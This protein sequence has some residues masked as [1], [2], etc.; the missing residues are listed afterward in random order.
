MDWTNEMYGFLTL[1]LLLLG[2][3]AGWSLF[4]GGGIWYALARSFSLLLRAMWQF[5]SF[6]RLVFSWVFQSGKDNQGGAR[7]AT[8]IE[9]R[10]LLSSR[11]G[12]L[13]LAP[14]K[15]L[16]ARDSF[17][18]LLLVA[19]SGAGKT[20]T[21]VIP[22]VLE[23][24][25]SMVVTD[26]AGEVFAKTSGCL[27]SRGFEINCFNLGDPSRS[28]RFNPLLRSAR[29]ARRL[30]RTI[31]CIVESQVGGG[32]ESFWP[33][34]ATDLLTTLAQAL[35]NQPDERLIT[36]RS[37]RYL[38][39]RFGSA[40]L[41]DFIAANL[42]D[43]ISFADYHSMRAG[44]Q[45]MVGS[46]VATARTALD[47]FS[48]E[49]ALE[50]LFS[51]DTLNLPGLRNRR[52]VLYIICPETRLSYFS[53]PLNLLYEELFSSLLEQPLDENAMPLFVIMDEAG[54]Q[55]I[56]DF[57][58]ILTTCRKRNISVSLVL[59]EISQLRDRY[60]PEKAKTIVSGGTGNRLIFPG[61]S[62]ESCH[63]FS[64]M[65]GY[66]LEKNDK[67][68]SQQR[69][70]LVSP[71][72]LRM[73]GNIL[74]SGRHRPVRLNPVPYYKDKRLRAL[75]KISPVEIAPCLDAFGPPLLPE[76]EPVNVDGNSI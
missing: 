68:G 65:L 44:G 63:L 5:L 38:V 34:A 52:S 11:A 17:N 33:K 66:R 46:I 53:L 1:A 39:S 41:D 64:E 37:L 56:R 14:G 47:I 42:P 76:L 25:C 22:A 75:A 73:S 70:P 49:P 35:C 7:F 71:D 51:G 69:L 32:S 19:P 9:E 20:S 21:F 29:D 48:S 24:E 40:E 31:S 54:N 58:V 28:V 62:P 74:I 2:A 8:F 18:H 16:S 27:Q 57:D 12:G 4:T 6:F 59:Q 60:G 23:S 72:E 50:A 10:R 55:Y 61:L 13:R 45:N 36:L 30:R 15:F 43:K 67:T 26:P 3:A